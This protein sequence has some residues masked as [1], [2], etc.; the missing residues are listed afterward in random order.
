MVAAGS[1]VGDEPFRLLN[2]LAQADLPRLLARLDA[3]GCR[4][5]T[6]QG[7]HAVDKASFL[8]RVAVDV[9][10]PEGMLP[11]S[12]DAFAD[13]LWNSLYDGGS[14][15]VALVWTG[16]QAMAHNDLGDLLDA[17]RVMTDVARQVL[18]TSAGFP[19]ETTLLLF[20]VGEG[21]EFR[22]LGPP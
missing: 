2:T 12:W 16:A 13:Y 11:D 9:P 14:D 17:V 3:Q 19:R 22:R 1:S 4:V 7:G 18:T 20:L 5:L 15:L 8:H 21:P 10:G 6:V